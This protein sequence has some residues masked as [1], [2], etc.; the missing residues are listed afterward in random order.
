[1]NLNFGLMV[2][3]FLR[4]NMEKEI[5]QNNFETVYKEYKEYESLILSTQEEIL[6]QREKFRDRVLKENELSLVEALFDLSIKPIQSEE[7]LRILRDRLITVYDSYKI[8]LDFPI[9]INTEISNLKRPYQAYR[10]DNGQQVDI[11]KT[12]NDL[13]KEKVKQRH[14]EIINQMKIQ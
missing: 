5:L 4:N 14:L 2:K 9:E 11:D 13:Y 12:K 8:V 3:T 7:D 1:M 10:I 6:K